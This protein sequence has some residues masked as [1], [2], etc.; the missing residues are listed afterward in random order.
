VAIDILYE[1]NH[2]LIVNKPAGLLT[3][4]NEGEGSS[5][6][7]LAKRY[8]KDKYEK[9]G[10]VYLEAV[11][12][13]DK[14]ASGAV[15][16]ARTSKAA[17]RLSAAIREKRCHK[18]YWALVEGTLEE[19]GTLDH[20][21]I[22]DDHYASVAIPDAAGA[23]RALLS[24]RV[25]GTDGS[26]T[27]VEIVLETGRYHQ[28]RAQFAAAGHPVIG[29]NKY[30]GSRSWPSGGIAL[31]SRTLELPHPTLQQNIAVTAAL[32]LCWREAMIRLMDPA[33][34]QQ[35]FPQKS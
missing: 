23:K 13:L 5:A 7:E 15:A 31:H 33:T 10:A 32:P 25:I 17:A 29:D 3:Q 1:D 6:E 19:Q 18:V 21:L 14:P 8:I 30:S 2:L 35:T 20:W 22:H 9:P 4:P 24:Y 34:I 16:F 28:I 26:T 27:L 12:R 11:H